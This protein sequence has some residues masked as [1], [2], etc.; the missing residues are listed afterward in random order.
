LRPVDLVTKLD[1]EPEDLGPVFFETLDL[2]KDGSLT[3]E[4][5]RP[6]FLSPGK[7]VTFEEMDDRF[8]R[9]DRDNNGRISPEELK[10]SVDKVTPKRLGTVIR[11]QKGIN[12]KT[13]CST[14]H[15]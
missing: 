8:A 15:R 12:P 1:W 4:E 10:T 5:A 3:I 14:C 9:S 13:N 2:D 7:D 6:G 11:A